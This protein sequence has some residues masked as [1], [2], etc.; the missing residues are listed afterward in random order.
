[1]FEVLT[2]RVIFLHWLC[3]IVLITHTHT[4]QKLT[5]NKLWKNQ[6]NK[7]QTTGNLI[8]TC[9]IAFTILLKPVNQHFDVDNVDDIA[10]ISHPTKLSPIA[11]AALS[12]VSYPK[13]TWSLS[14]KSSISFLEALALLFAVY[15]KSNALWSY[16]TQVY[17]SYCSC[18]CKSELL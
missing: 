10:T 11:S 18:T 16:F 6:W 8:P 15:E 3:N 1:M 4:T 5:R 14:T 7:L 2:G 13:H 17:E 12:F 9:L